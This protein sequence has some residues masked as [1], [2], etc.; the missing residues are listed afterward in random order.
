MASTGGEGEVGSL[1]ASSLDLSAA[2]AALR[3]A[4]AEVAQVR[5]E[6]GGEPWTTTGLTA[7]Q[8]APITWLASGD[9]WIGAPEGTHL[10]AG[11]QLRVR[12]G[13]R[14]PALSGTGATFT[15]AAPHDGPIEVCSIYPGELGA[16]DRIVYDPDFPRALFD[17]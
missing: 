16:D 7:S 12:T 4:G 8:G 5:V 6:A 11:F 13:M 3:S 15:T 17:R 10:G 9:S 1:G 2:A 14:G